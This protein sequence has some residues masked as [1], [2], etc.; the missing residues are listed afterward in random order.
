MIP[1]KLS[2]GMGNHLLWVQYTK[3]GVIIHIIVQKTN[4]DP[5]IIVHHIK[6]DV[7]IRIS[8]ALLNSPF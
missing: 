4:R 1:S 3:S 8:I 7:N 6:N 5:F 2:L